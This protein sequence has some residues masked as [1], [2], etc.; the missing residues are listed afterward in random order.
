MIF[1]LSA[2]SL[3]LFAQCVKLS[4]NPV[5]SLREN[6]TLHQVFKLFLGT[7]RLSDH[8]AIYNPIV[9]KILS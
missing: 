2:V 9:N 1:S 3:V 7:F 8:T 5:I 6:P 4:R